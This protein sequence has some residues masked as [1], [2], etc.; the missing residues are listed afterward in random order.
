L[1]KYL[2]NES[3]GKI[4]DICILVNSIFYFV[5]CVF[6]ISKGGQYQLVVIHNGKILMDKPY[7]T[8]RGA[9]IAF[10]RF[11]N[12]RSWRQGI[13]AEW[14]LFYKPDTGWLNEMKGRT[15]IAHITA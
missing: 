3:P 6:I 14:S 11:F 2:K 8:L 4:E 1:T 5:G 9:K 15:K 12:H 7:N 13:K 10:S